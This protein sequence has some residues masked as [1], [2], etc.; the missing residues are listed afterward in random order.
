M[1]E[2]RPG[3]WCA[4][5]NR[6][7]DWLLASIPV[8]QDWVSS[9]CRK[10]YLKRT[11]HRWRGPFYVAWDARKVRRKQSVRQ[12][13]GTNSSNYR[14]SVSRETTVC[15]RLTLRVMLRINSSKPQFRGA[16]GQL[17]PWDVVDNSRIKYHVTLQSV[18]FDEVKILHFAILARNFCLCDRRSDHFE[19]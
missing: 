5:N 10:R 2:S 17:F 9:W 3:I 6:R 12:K 18:Q 16:C 1:K 4:D 14:Y 11:L 19:W 15:I 7:R 8:G 13:A